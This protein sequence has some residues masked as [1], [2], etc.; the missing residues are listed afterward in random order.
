MPI[1]RVATPLKAYPVGSD[2]GEKFP[3]AAAI[4]ISNPI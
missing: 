4:G 1:G 2:S 3:L